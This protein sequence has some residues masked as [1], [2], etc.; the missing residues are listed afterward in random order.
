MNAMLRC[1]LGGLLL[2]AALPLAAAADEPA[3]L[4]LVL[5]VDASSSINRS[6]FNQQMVGLAEA[7][8][9][10]RVQQAID[11]AGPFGVAVLLL[12]WADSRHQ[13]V[14]IDWVLVHSAQDCEA[15]AQL[16][17]QTPRQVVGGGT[18]I[19]GALA[20]SMAELEANRYQG[21]RQVIDVSGDGRANQGEIP[22]LVRDRAVAAGI[23]VNG[24]AILNEDPALNV[25]YTQH[26]IGGPNAFVLTA[27]DYEAFRDAMIEKLVKEITGAPVAAA[28]ADGEQRAQR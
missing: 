19:G 11:G 1:T 6:E 7:F 28:P 17:D 23:T 21:A 20:F 9:H 8:R 3:D 22:S 27:P 5:A 26:V 12:Q 15:L 25:Y 13:E 2:A 4:E 14:S 10:P 16:I 24:L 18:A